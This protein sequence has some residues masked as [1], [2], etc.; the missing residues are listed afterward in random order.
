MTTQTQAQATKR[1]WQYQA[2]SREWETHY[3]GYDTAKCLTEVF[4]CADEANALLIIKAVNEY[5]EKEKTLAF[6]SG[7][8]S[9]RNIEIIKLTNQKQELV[10]AI[11]YSL[12]F[13]QSVCAHSNQSEAF[14]NLSRAFIKLEETLIK[15]E[16]E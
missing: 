2:P 1:P 4:E 15:S 16:K 8:A 13:I 6:L 3:K 12:P 7:V 5:D 10:E 9:D 11:K 14:I